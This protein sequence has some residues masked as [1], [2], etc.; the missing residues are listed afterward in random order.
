MRL[1]DRPVF[2]LVNGHDRV[3]GTHR[4]CPQLS[5]TK[6]RRRHTSVVRRPDTARSRTLRRRVSCTARHLNPQS[7]HRD[8][9]RVDATSTT[10]SLSVSTATAN[11]RINRRCNRTRITSG[12]VGALLDRCAGTHRV[13]LGPDPRRWTPTSRS[14]HVHAQGQKTGP[15]APRDRPLHQAIS[16][17]TALPDPPR[18][19][20][21]LDIGVSVPPVA[22][23]G[24]VPDYYWMMSRIV[25]SSTTGVISSSLT[26]DHA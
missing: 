18:G 25:S 16:R 22:L 12:D 2:S 8:H 23:N 14:S 15:L 6:R 10:N 21:R 1:Q 20:R 9:D 19:P 24:T 11:T 17:P 26:S 4:R 5:Q 3:S 7:G 13:Q